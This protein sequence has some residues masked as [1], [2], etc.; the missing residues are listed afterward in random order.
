MLFSIIDS[1]V[2]TVHSSITFVLGQTYHE[3]RERFI[4]IYDSF[5]VYFMAFVFSLFTVAYVLILPFMKLYTDGINDINY[6]DLW[7]P[8]LFVSLK[9]LS[10]ARTPANTA[11][12]IAGHF[13]ETKNR[14]I[15]EAIINLVCSLLLVNILG[16][17]GVLIGTI[18]ALL[19]RS[20]DMIFY[21]SKNILYRKSWVTFRRWLINIGLFLVLIFISET[22]KINPSS[23]LEIFL[24]AVLL[25]VIIIPVYFIICSLF[26]REVYTY[27]FGY[28]RSFL[29][30]VPNQA[31][32]SSSYAK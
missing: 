21:S 28:L 25:C 22:L 2:H 1:I 29:K 5:E 11:I 12:N 3:N 16:I 17:Y 7:L 23:Y 19:Y 30:K 27:S 4:K 26:E 8:I 6:I 14:S 20:A 24:L 31:T 18:L 32:K 13:K 10:L 9:L 15:F